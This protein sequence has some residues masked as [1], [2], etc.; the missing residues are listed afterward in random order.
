[1]RSRVEVYS[2]REPGWP[3]HQN[4]NSLLTIALRL[5]RRYGD[6]IPEVSELV[7]DFGVHRATAYR[8]R[9]AFRDSMEIDA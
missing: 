9:A 2:M 1:M 8:W 3:S 7:R 6:R 4:T 5:V